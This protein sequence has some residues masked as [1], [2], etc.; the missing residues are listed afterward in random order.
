M[1]KVLL[2]YKDTTTDQIGLESLWATPVGENYK[3]DNVPFLSK[4]FALG[5]IVAVEK[6]DGGLYVDSLVEA[7]GHGVIQVV[8]FGEQ[9]IQSFLDLLTEMQFYWEQS[10]IKKM[11][12]IDIPNE[13]RYLVL[14]TELEKWMGL[15]KLDYREACLGW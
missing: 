7:S 5:D 4:N 9:D 13:E 6:T 3:L 12:A 15:D 10:H 1:T 2:P 11:I 8:L 14:V